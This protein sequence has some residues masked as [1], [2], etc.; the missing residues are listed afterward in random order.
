MIKSSINTELLY[1]LT[2]SCEKYDNYF[3]AIPNNSVKKQTNLCKVNNHLQYI[4]GLY[5]PQHISNRFLTKESYPSIYNVYTSFYSIINCNFD[6]RILNRDPSKEHVDYD[7]ALKFLKEVDIV[8]LFDNCSTNYELI[9]IRNENNLRTKIV[10]IALGTVAANGFIK[11]SNLLKGKDCVWVSCLSD[12][13]ILKEIYSHIEY[14]YIPFGVD[15]EFF[16]PIQKDDNLIRKV[17]LSLGINND[18]LLITYGG[19]IHPEKNIH[20]L[21][22][23]F[24]KV[25]KKNGKATLCIAGS[26]NND[27]SAPFYSNLPNYYEYIRTL[28][29][30][31]NLESHIIFIGA[32][33]RNSLP[34]I[35]GSSEIVVD[36]SICPTEN[37]GYMPVEAMSC[38]VPIVASAIGGIKD[39]VVHGK[40]GYLIDTILTRNG[41]MVDIN[42]AADRILSLLED[43]SKR[44]R[45]GEF[46]RLRSMNFSIEKMNDNV[47]Q[48]I[49]NAKDAKDDAT[50]SSL[51]NALKKELVY[52]LQNK[53]VSYNV[54]KQTVG[55]YVSIN[56]EKITIPPEFKIQFLGK[57]FLKY[58]SERFIL[59]V[60]NPLHP[61][62]YELDNEEY[63]LLNR[64]KVDLIHK[65]Q[66]FSEG[67]LATIRY[68]AQEGFIN[69]VN[70]P[71]PSSIKY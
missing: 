24:R 40:T 51:G 18:N 3:A 28:I 56:L 20:G 67:E 31:Y 17:K 42:D 50:L 65:M 49:T 13:E 14:R 4:V 33:P 19:R 1:Q 57:Y 27:I 22:E 58:E 21:I 29:K 2:Q 71:R 16:Q 5:L 64:L 46:A 37:F 45:L 52:Q 32:Q 61:I 59:E 60:C 39:T 10:I 7:K 63:M 36:F 48:A 70:T 55:H 35:Y 38:G 69:I 12:I 23:I 43:S 9:N 15:T 11:Y 8:I 25:V 30:E 34:V 44:T 54:F 6:A 41:I 62:T 68:F 47:V 66:D 53:S 26:I